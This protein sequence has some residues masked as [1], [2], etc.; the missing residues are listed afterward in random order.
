VGQIN[1]RVTDNSGTDNIQL[2][3]LHSIFKYGRKLLELKLQDYQQEHDLANENHSLN[4]KELLIHKLS[5]IVTPKNF[6]KANLICKDISTSESNWKLL[7]T[8]VFSKI[9]VENWVYIPEEAHIDLMG[10]DN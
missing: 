2:P 6:F 10:N 1:W 7:P 8:E 5:Q 4:A 3:Y 9:V